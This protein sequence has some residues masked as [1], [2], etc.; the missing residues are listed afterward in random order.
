MPGLLNLLDLSQDIVVQPLAGGLSA[1]LYFKFVDGKPINRDLL[2]KS[3][4]VAGAVAVS[5]MSSE[6]VREKLNLSQG[7]LSDG[8][9]VAV[10]PLITGLSLVALGKMNP[11]F[12]VAESNIKTVLLASTFDA[13]AKFLVSPIRQIAGQN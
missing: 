11:K 1:M 3:A 12:K 8:V 7:P 4:G 13:S 2:M 10:E 9:A 6:Y 5:N